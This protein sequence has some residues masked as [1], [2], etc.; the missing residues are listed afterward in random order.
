MVHRSQE[1]DMPI[2]TIPNS[3]SIH[4]LKSFLAANKPFSDSSGPAR[5]VMHPKWAHM[6]PMA[7]AMSAAWGGW[8]HRQRRGCEIAIENTE[9]GH[10]NYAR[11]MGLFKLLNVPETAALEEHEEA[12]RFLPLAQVKTPFELAAVIADI[13]ALLHLDKEPDGLAAVQ[14]CVSE[15][16]RNV[17]EHSGSPE[18]AYI[19]AQRYTNKR[20]KR[21]SI[22]VA[23]CGW[24]IAEHIGNSYPE[25]RQNYSLALRLAMQPGI[26]GAYKDAMYGAT[27]NAGAGLFITRAIAKAT[28]GYFVLLSGDTAF[29]LL[30]A[31][32]KDQPLVYHDAFSDPRHDLWVTD[33]FWQG[34][35]AAVEIAT[36]KIP[37]FQAFFQWIRKQVPATKTAA[38]KIKF[39]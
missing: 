24:G 35:V 32:R 25:A 15:L 33:S 14:Y 28:G 11:R 22:A 3:A 18:G 10:T 23:D 8:C 20:P 17:L 6:D 34:T 13:S 26:T 12:G 16:L 7:L 27:D 38:G 30:R 37:D 2:F 1:C 9:G 39:T 36:E 31:R 21:V 5:L 4:T 29:R 19:C